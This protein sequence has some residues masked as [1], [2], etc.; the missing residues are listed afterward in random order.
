MKILYLKNEPRVCGELLGNR[1][2]ELLDE[3]KSV[4][5]LVPG[6]SNIPISVEAMKIIRGKTSVQGLSHLTISLTD[7]RY[8][9]VGHADSNW[10]QLLNAG[11]SFDGVKAIPVL[12]GLSV[13][14]TVQK[15][16]ES[17]L[18]AMSTVDVVV[19]QF[20]IGADGHIAGVLPHTLGVTSTE[21][22]IFYTSEPYVRIS[23]S[24]KTIE[25][26]DSAY[27][28]A[29]GSS[30][31]KTLA[32]LQNEELSLDDQPSQVLKKIVESFL[33]ID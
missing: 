7:E 20:G 19:G 11:F 13:E 32:R 3:D 8:G 17:V 5:W 22:T 24:L 29:F 16:G 12:A 33:C 9:E 21:S 6:G 15:Y 25:K 31:S 10:Q 30:K 14:E 2:V 26:I 4:L 27:A 28:F 23:L 1:I 18:F